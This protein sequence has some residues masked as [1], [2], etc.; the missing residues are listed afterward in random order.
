MMDDQCKKTEKCADNKCES[1]PECVFNPI[2][3]DLNKT[4]LKPEAKEALK[5]VAECLKKTGA[6]IQLEGHTDNKGKPP[7]NLATSEKMA[8]AVKKQ[9]VSLGVPEEQINVISFGQDKPVCEEDTKECMQ[10]NRRVELV[11]P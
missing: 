8:N 6:K 2:Y 4:T 9:L 3:F 7:A 1:I 10:K 11:V 5:T